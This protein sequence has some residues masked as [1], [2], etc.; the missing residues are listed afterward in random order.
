MNI[1]GFAR[2]G[3]PWVDVSDKFKPLIFMHKEFFVETYD[4]LEDSVKIFHVDTMYTHD[5]NDGTPQLDL[6]TIDWWTNA[7]RIYELFSVQ[8]SE[9]AKYLSAERKFIKYMAT[10]V[11][12]GT[13]L[14]S[15]H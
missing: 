12:K 6:Y 5:G 15:D 11:M 2:E 7:I 4:R 13:F 1:D 14:P 9:A 3:L 10:R 8:P